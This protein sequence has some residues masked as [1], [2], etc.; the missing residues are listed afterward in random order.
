MATMPS[1]E[2]TAERAI[3]SILPQVSSLWLFLDRFESVPSFANHERIRVLRSQ[4]LGDLRSYGKF[5]VLTL[6]TVDCTF[7]GVDDDIEYP[8]NYCEKLERHL[9]GYDGQVVVGVHAENLR[10][11]IVSYR[12]SRT[13]AHYR[14]RRRFCDEVDVLGTGSLAFRSSTLHFDV[15]DWPHVNMGDLSF[16]LTARSR[17]VPLLSISRREGWLTTLAEAQPDSI[18][19]AVRRD[20]S[21]QTLLARELLTLPRP[22]LPRRRGRAQR[23]FARA[24]TSSPLAR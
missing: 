18:Y 4:D 20:D 21:M 17:R 5:A 2:A 10:P 11:P 8:P 14:L 23:L 1:R 24:R 22:P 7:F 12:R 6:S 13:I 9:D 3:A 15:R 16:A 19:R